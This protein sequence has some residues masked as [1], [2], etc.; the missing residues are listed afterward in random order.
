[1]ESPPRKTADERARELIGQAIK[2][3]REKAEMSQSEAAKAL[4]VD[5][6]TLRRWEAGTGSLWTGGDAGHVDFAMM[7]K[8]KEVYGARMSE[9]LPRNQ[10]PSAPVDPEKRQEWVWRR[11]ALIQ[12]VG[13][14]DEY[15]QTQRDQRDRTRALGSD[16]R[17]T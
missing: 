15:V 17:K 16:P 13:D 3:R 8:L 10:Y 7:T 5:E 6:R 1:M 14:V 12:G 4:G 2:L 11:N 9:L